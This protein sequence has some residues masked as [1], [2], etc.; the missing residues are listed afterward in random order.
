MPR[1]RDKA[2]RDYVRGWES[3][4]RRPYLYKNVPPTNQRKRFGLKLRLRELWERDRFG[5]LSVGSAVVATLLWAVPINLKGISYESFS[6]SYGIQG[7]GTAVDLFVVTIYDR[8]SPIER[9]SG[10]SASWAENWFQFDR[11]PAILF[12]LALAG[13]L[14]VQR[15]LSGGA[16]SRRRFFG[17]SAFVPKAIKREVLWVS[18]GVFLLSGLLAYNLG[19]SAG[20]DKGYDFGYDK[21]YDLGIAEGYNRGYEEGFNEGFEEGYR[22]GYLSGCS[23][24][25]SR[26]ESYLF[27]YINCYSP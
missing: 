7:S 22:D 13:F 27:I 25:R 18:L 8:C 6:C 26:A 1:S 17:A 11:L 2:K 20:Y 9:V 4:S 16:T 12:F 15:S 23:Y 5:V 21:G 24:A 3:A 10:I 14:I 19:H